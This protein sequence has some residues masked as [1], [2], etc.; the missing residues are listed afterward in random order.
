MRTIKAPVI[1]TDAAGGIGTVIG[2]E[3]VGLG[4][5]SAGFIQ[6]GSLFLYG[7]AGVDVGPQRINLVGEPGVVEVIGDDNTRIRI[8]ASGHITVSDADE[9][10]RFSVDATGAVTVAD[11]N[12]TFS[13]VVSAGQVNLVNTSPGFSSSIAIEAAGRMTLT[14]ALGNTAEYKASGWTVNG[15]AGCSINGGNLA[16]T[17]N[18]TVSGDIFLPG[19]DCAEHFDVAD[20]AL[21]P[22]TVLVLEEAGILAESQRAYDRTVV[23]VVSGAGDHRPGIILDR[24][25]ATEGRAPV[26]L[27]GKVFC[28][29]DATVAPIAVG[30]LLTTSRTPGHAM[31]ADDP[32]RAF[33]AVL[34]K[35]LRKLDEGRGLIPILV[36]L[37]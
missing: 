26:A 36:A 19:A 25:T 23:G 21:E 9:N 12:G 6:A 24:K 3:A 4:G 27:V 29:A 11:E 15:D 16:V 33:G 30:D 18:L 14:D 8:D 5:N 35:A 31:R 34:G 28:K 32:T 7:G 1:I 20:A 2:P 37:Q 13:V 17:N 10:V 22:G